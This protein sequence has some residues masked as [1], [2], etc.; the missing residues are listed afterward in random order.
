MSDAALCSCDW[1]QVVLISTKFLIIFEI[2]MSAIKFQAKVS[3][4]AKATGI[5]RNGLVRQARD[6]GLEAAKRS[7]S[8]L[9]L[10]KIATTAEDSYH[11]GS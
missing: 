2:R 5:T 7:G 11:D 9:P 8:E 10:W 4:S 3:R 6:T 1:V